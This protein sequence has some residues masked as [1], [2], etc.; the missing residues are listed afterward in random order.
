[1]ALVEARI[2]KMELPN[3][4]IGE[5]ENGTLYK[6]KGGVLGQLVLLSTSKKKGKYRKAKLLEILEKSELETLDNES[7]LNL[8]SGNRF[9][10]IPYEKEL[11]I[12]SE[13]LQELYAQIDWQENIKLNPS[14]LVA[15][16]RNKM[17]YTFGDEYIGGPLMLG[18]HKIGHFYEITDYSGGTIV[19]SGFDKLRRFTQE[20][21]R[22]TD[23]KHHHKTKHEGELKFFVIRYSFYENAFMLNL[24]TSSSEKVSDQIL[25]DYVNEVLEVD[26]DGE[27]VSIYHTISDSIADAIKPDEINLLYG[28]ADLTE[29]ING[30]K[31]KISPFSFFQ[32]NPLG[33]ENLYNKALELA[34]NLENK[35][36]FDLYS[37]T[38]TI[39]QI[40][41]KKAKS[42]VGVEIV[43]E[44][45]IKARENAELNNLSNICFRANDVLDELDNLT[46]APDI[47]VL[48]PPRMG[49]HVSALPKIAELGADT[50]VYISCNPDT[51]VEDIL[52]FKEF[53]YKVLSIE[54]FDQFP[55]TMHVECV[56]LLSKLQTEHLLDID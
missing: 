31:F 49:I 56:T 34:D 29:E 4:S 41:A 42:V 37:G 38:G 19:N 22:N 20:F 1:M 25:S 30:L 43:E 40:F 8:M 18:M 27:V 24:V 35:T 23:L 48:D 52:S 6:F 21:F 3:F 33:A 16:Y 46:D 5:D 55:R 15:A 39:S 51:Q 28:K 14:P 9:D 53:G 45:V 11:E 12:K 44:A 7:Q 50:I 10:N 26:I 2:I 13:M 54:A 47:I 36:V 17:E 32:P